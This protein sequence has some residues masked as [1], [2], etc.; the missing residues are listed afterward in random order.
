MFKKWKEKFKKKKEPITKS[1]WTS[2]NGF[3]NNETTENKPHK[4]P[5]WG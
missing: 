1:E 2:K 3:K 4:G 5:L